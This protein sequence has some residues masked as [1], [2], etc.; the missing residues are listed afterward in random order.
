MQLFENLQG[1]YYP[2]TDCQGKL[3]L[4]RSEYHPIGNRLQYPK[5][6]GRKRAA[7]LLLEH[8]IK[9]ERDTIESAQAELAKLERC[10]SDVQG[11]DDDSKI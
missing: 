2:V 4:I 9:V 3:N 1:E 11:W 10:L 7:T 6:W 5:K 8:K